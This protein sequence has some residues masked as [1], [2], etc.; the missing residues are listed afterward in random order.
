MPAS[1]VFSAVVKSF[2]DKSLPVTL[3]T[4]VAKLAATSVA[5]AFKL[6]EV[7][8]S[9]VLALSASAVFVASA[10]KSWS[11]VLV[12]VIAASF[13]FSAVV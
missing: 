12:P 3:S 1:F 2:V 9:V 8:T 5:F 10:L 4:F 11:P 7:F 6:S 13:V